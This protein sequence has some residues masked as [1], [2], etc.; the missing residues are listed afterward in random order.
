MKQKIRL[1]KI[2]NKT[3]SKLFLAVK[4]IPKFEDKNETKIKTH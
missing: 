4:N 3:E 2:S 1:N